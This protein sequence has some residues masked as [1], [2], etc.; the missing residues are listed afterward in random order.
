M[1]DRI[2]RVHYS[3]RETLLIIDPNVSRI[4]RLKFFL[5]REVFEFGRS[6]E[7]IEI[8]GAAEKRVS[9]C[10]LQE[11]TYLDREDREIE[12]GGIGNGY[13]RRTNPFRVRDTWTNLAINL[14]R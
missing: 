3:T 7:L 8:L 9:R 11:F 5:P 14:G 12:L 10:V 4:S 1:R 2:L 13:P 6:E